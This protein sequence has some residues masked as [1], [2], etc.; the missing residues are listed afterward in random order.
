[1]EV[2]CALGTEATP[3][4]DVA[5]HPV[6]T[7]TDNTAAAAAS[8]VAVFTTQTLPTQWQEVKSLGQTPA[9]HGNPICND[10][11]ARSI[12]RLLGMSDSWMEHRRGLDGELLGW[13][14]PV[15]E[16]FIAIDLLGREVTGVVEWLDAEETLDDLGIGYLADPFELRLETGQW[17]RVRLAEV[18]AQEIRVKTDDW[19]DMS[20]PQV[21]YTL[22]FPVLERLRALAG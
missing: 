13:M 7:A 1:M 3:V 4:V 14:K 19:G 11:G 18:S 2:S 20:A 9:P 15:G 5:A 21:Y 17:L 10:L 6:N 16:G 22:R 8:L 12:R